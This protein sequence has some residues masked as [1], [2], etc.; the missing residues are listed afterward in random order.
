MEKSYRLSADSWQTSPPICTAPC[1]SGWNPPDD[2][3]RIDPIAN[4]RCY[5]CAALSKSWVADRSRGT[6]EPTLRSLEQDFAPL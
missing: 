1:M 4:V 2:A 3:A 5:G 6:C